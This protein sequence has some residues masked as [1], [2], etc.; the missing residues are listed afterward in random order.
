MKCIVLALTFIVKRRSKGTFKNELEEIKGI[1]KSTIDLLL[2]KFRSINNIR[3][4]SEE[5]LSEVIGKSKARIIHD[6]FN[7]TSDINKKKGPG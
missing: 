5:E 6:Y 2:K 3:Q 4:K 1:G 7:D